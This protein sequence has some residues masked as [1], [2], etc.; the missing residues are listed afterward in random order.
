[1]STWF[2]IKH[3]EPITLCTVS[4]LWLCSRYKDDKDLKDLEEKGIN[5]DNHF[6][7]ERFMKLLEQCSV[8]CSMYMFW[9]LQFPKTVTQ[10]A[11]QKY[12]LSLGKGT[13]IG[14]FLWSMSILD[15]GYLII[16]KHQMHLIQAHPSCA[17]VE[18]FHQVSITC[19]HW[20]CPS[21]V[22]IR[23]DLRK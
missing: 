14:T 22:S 23:W 12:W 17:S 4:V 5:K 21:S 11:K 15:G 2:S 6:G 20:A 8:I 1:M 9:L 16:N 18:C 3:T 7:E 19:V 10:G 13:R